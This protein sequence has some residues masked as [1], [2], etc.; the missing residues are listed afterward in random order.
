[1][2]YAR[3]RYGATV[4]TMLIISNVYSNVRSRRGYFLTYST[5]ACSTIE[6]KT[7]KE[8]PAGKIDKMEGREIPGKMPD[9]NERVVKY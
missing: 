1:M 7:A 9:K 8:T 2:R 6:R 3:V 4:R 5:K